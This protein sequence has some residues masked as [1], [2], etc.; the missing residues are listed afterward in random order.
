M[1]LLVALL[2][3]VALLFLAPFRLSSRDVPLLLPLPGLL[4][5]LTAFRL[6][7][8]LLANDIPARLRPGGRTFHALRGRTLRLHL[9]LKSRPLAVLDLTLAEL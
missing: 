5:L 4:L 6:A 8:L 2:R 9:S 1:L 3:L 7:G